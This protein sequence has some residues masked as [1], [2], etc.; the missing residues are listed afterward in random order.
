M[1]E[2]QNLAN[3]KRRKYRNGCAGKKAHPTKQDAIDNA[4][5]M[6]LLNERKGKEGNQM[7]VYLC[8]RCGLFHLSRQT[9]KPGTTVVLLEPEKEDTE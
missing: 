8:R 3:A 1:R 4:A 9:D 2:R 5:K 6:L 7:G